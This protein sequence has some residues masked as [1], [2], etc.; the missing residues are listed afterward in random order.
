VAVILLVGGE[1][2]S[3]AS[4]GHPHPANVF[5][6][7]DAGTG[8]AQWL[9]SDAVLDSWQGHFFDAGAVRRRIPEWFGA[10]SR[11]HW[12]AAAPDMQLPPPE[13]Q[14]LSD[15]I[16]GATR[17]ID[18][19]VK[20]RRG[21]RDFRLQVIGNRVAKA[22]AQGQIVPPATTDDWSLAAYNLPPEGMTLR[23]F[24]AVGRP[25]AVNLFDITPGL[26]MV[27]TLPRDE[28]HVAHRSESSDTTQSLAT[29]RFD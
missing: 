10:D 3:G 22:L 17:V 1:V 26:P 6:V 16:D 4:A 24:V 9:S 5:Y 19:Q 27:D 15:R 28:T 12:T 11:L 13:L 18:L 21:A 29:H 14:T 8:T 2:T 25:F 23:L 7:R 20:S